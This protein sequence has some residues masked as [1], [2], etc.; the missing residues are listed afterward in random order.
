MTKMPI[1]TLLSLVVIAASLQAAPPKKSASA[2]GALIARAK[3]VVVENMKDPE[4]TQFRNVRVAVD[5]RSHRKVCGEANGKNSYGAYVGYARFAFDGD[6]VTWADR[7]G[8]V[9]WM[10][11]S[12][13]C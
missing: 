11:A 6:A 10:L 1:A 3:A 2:N 4:A 5:T 9:A 7:D 12:E 8:Q 13:G